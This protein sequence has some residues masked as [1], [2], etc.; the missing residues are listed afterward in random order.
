MRT[1]VRSHSR[2]ASSRSPRA[3]ECPIA[4]GALSFG[5]RAR[6]ARR[7]EQTAIPEHQLAPARLDEAE[8]RV[9]DVDHD[10]V[11]QPGDDARRN[12]DQAPSLVEP[13]LAEFLAHR[14]RQAVPTRDARRRKDLVGEAPGDG[15]FDGVPV[16]RQP[17]AAADQ[18]FEQRRRNM[19][20]RSDER[21]S[22]RLPSAGSQVGAGR[23]E[24]RA[25]PDALDPLR[26][27]EHSPSRSA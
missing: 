25:V 15:D 23:I 5:L 27:S 13:L 21:A 1:D 24:D 19:L 11:I 18:L 7:A 6:S 22:G 8:S 17:P 3:R 20:A 14:G 12:Q 10:I 26:S 16:R 2:P 4:P 9:S